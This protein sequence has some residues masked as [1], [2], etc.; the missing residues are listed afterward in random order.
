MFRTSFIG[1]ELVGGSELRQ[2]NKRIVATAR[3][4]FDVVGSLFPPPPHPF[5]SRKI[6][7]GERCASGGR[8][9][10]RIPVPLLPMLGARGFG[11]S[12]WQVPAGGSLSRQPWS[13]AIHLVRLSRFLHRLPAS[14]LH[15]TVHGG[16]YPQPEKTENKAVDSTESRRSLFVYSWLFGGDSVSH[17]W[18]WLY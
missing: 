8:V 11:Q 17:L 18:R 15:W 9:H 12:R 7:G 4:P 14:S 6:I 16:R 2:A 5:R 10:A 1:S 13:Q 3:K